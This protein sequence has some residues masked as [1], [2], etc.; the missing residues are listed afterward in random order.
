MTLFEMKQK[1]YDNYDK[2][3][4]TTEEEKNAIHR[5]YLDDLLEETAKWLKE[6]DYFIEK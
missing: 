1:F 6:N 4:D 2:V 5:A 3:L